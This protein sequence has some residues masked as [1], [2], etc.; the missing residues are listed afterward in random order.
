M[1]NLEPQFQ[2]LPII[3]EHI[4]ADKMAAIFFQS[5]LSHENGCILIQIKWT[6]F[7][8]KKR[9]IGITMSSNWQK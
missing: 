1:L 9:L 3:Y 5:R 7:C 4:L 2:F 6:F 8:N